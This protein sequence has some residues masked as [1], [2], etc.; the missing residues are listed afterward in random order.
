MVKFLLALAL[1]INSLSPDDRE[2]YQ[3]LIPIRILVTE[4]YRL[5]PIISEIETFLPWMWILLQ[6]PTKTYIV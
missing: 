3:H 2:T 5:E 1:D 6:T 4:Y